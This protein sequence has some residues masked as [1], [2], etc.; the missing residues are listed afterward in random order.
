MLT[1]SLA[2]IPAAIQNPI[3]VLA[4]EH[5]TPF[6]PTALARSG[7]HKVSD[8]T[9][10]GIASFANTGPCDYWGRTKNLVSDDEE[11]PRNKKAKTTIA[12]PEV[13]SPK[14]SPL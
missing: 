4:L 10:V 13:L 9:T 8:S 12:L 6:F 1:H 2:N 3:R 7:I 14:R 11:C 5:E